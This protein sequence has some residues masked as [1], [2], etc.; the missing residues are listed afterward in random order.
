MI[1]R[2]CE[3]LKDEI[4]MERQSGLDFKDRN[5][6]PSEDIACLCLQW[7]TTALYKKYKKRIIILIDEYD[8]QAHQS[9]VFRE[10]ALGSS[11]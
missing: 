11:V 9:M 2:Y 5:L 1:N 8:T 4:F 10:L 6:L 3:E 7:L